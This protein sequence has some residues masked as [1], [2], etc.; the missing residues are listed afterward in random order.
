M[1]LIM[2]VLVFEYGSA[3][4]GKFDLK[5]HDIMIDVTSLCYAFTYA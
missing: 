1:M 5:A 2:N 4:L 3:S